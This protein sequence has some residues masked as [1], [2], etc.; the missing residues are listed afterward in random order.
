MELHFIASVEPAPTID[1]S[2]R[3]LYWFFRQL[4][5]KLQTSAHTKL[6]MLCFVLLK[7]NYTGNAMLGIAELLSSSCLR[8]N[9]SCAMHEA[10]PKFHQRC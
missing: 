5:L 1:G 2:T 10:L 9:E 7:H 8:N 3:A 6:K 4:I